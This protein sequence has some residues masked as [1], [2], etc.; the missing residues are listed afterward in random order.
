MGNNPPAWD[1][2]HACQ[3]FGDE[4]PIA[5]TFRCGSDVGARCDGRR[6]SRL[7]GARRSLCGRRTGL[8]DT[9][10]PKRS[11]ATLGI[12]SS[13]GAGGCGAE[14][15][16]RAGGRGA[17]GRAP[18]GPRSM[19]GRLLKTAR[20]SRPM[21]QPGARTPH[22]HRS[23]ESPLMRRANAQTWCLRPKR[24][25]SHRGRLRPCRTTG[26]DGASST[27]GGNTA[28]EASQCDG[29]GWR[30]GPPSCC[31]RVPSRAGVLL[32]RRQEV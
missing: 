9:G 11:P 16:G 25:G 2:G 1:R 13:R 7:C 24:L 10:S 22:H 8:R 26:I 14:A 23:S 18:T 3:E 5:C 21:R 31:D 19:W 6:A 28:I 17:G 4:L 29:G 15:R 27:A 12:W 32:P 30:C 20:R